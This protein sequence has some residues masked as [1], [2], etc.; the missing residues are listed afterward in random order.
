MSVDSL[1]SLNI[2]KSPPKTLSHHQT[3]AQ[4]T[5]REC[6]PNDTTKHPHKLMDTIGGLLTPNSQH[7][8]AGIRTASHANSRCTAITSYSHHNWLPLPLRRPPTPLLFAVTVT[9]PQPRSQEQLPSPAAAALIS[10][11][12]HKWTQ[13]PSPA[14]FPMP[15][16]LH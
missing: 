10:C 1:T 6:R 13:P 7:L 9:R 14:T 12:G 8:V 16:H 3:F 15:G 2:H 5:A 4:A 11:N